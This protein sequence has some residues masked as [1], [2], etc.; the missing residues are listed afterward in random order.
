MVLLE[1]DVILLLSQA[2]EKGVVGLFTVD[3]ELMEEDCQR[4]MPR[5]WDKLNH[6]WNVKLCT[7]LEDEM[8]DWKCWRQRCMVDGVS[9]VRRQV[10]SNKQLYNNNAF[11]LLMFGWDYSIFSAGRNVCQ[12]V[13]N[14][15][16]KH[17]R[18]VKGE[19]SPFILK[20]QLEL[21][22]Q[23]F[24]ATFQLETFTYID[25]EHKVIKSLG[26]DGDVEYHE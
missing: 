15:Q 5:L 7:P 3:K 2:V 12:M 24:E 11:T 10:W 23:M 1:S 16:G 21:L 17:I 8:N 22:D 6:E 18:S 9:Q 20:R 4:Y 13:K 14:C 25:L 19:N 26:E